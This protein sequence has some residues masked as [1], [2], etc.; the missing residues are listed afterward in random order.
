M[1][2]K[3]LDFKNTFPFPTY[4]IVP[5]FK[6]ASFFVPKARLFIHVFFVT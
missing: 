3:A 4:P 1:H 6:N 2:I 5:P